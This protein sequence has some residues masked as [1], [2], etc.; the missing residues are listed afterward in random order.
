MRRILFLGSGKVVASL[1]KERAVGEE[2]PFAPTVP[3]PPEDMIMLNFKSHFHPYEKNLKYA[4][5]NSTTEMRK[6]WIFYDISIV[7]YQHWNPYL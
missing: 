1:T 4:E 7:L 3:H 2:R 6:S 5:D